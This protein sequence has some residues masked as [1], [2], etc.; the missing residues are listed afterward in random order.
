MVDIEKDGKKDEGSGI[1][2]G[3]RE[4]E[5]EDKRG[6]RARIEPVPN[7]GQVRPIRCFARTS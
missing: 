3:D 6:R 4:T 5:R 1:D 2:E 7:K